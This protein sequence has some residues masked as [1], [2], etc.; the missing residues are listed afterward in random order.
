MCVRV[1]RVRT[2]RTLGKA[3]PCSHTHMAG[4][5]AEAHRHSA[6][7]A[8]RSSQCLPGLCVAMVPISQAPSGARLASVHT[9]LPPS[10][11]PSWPVSWR[12]FPS[13]DTL[14]E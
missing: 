7:P 2:P 13:W 1:M 11:T 8:L 5:Q 9:P 6:G 14:G 10:P 3:P 4:T 12:A